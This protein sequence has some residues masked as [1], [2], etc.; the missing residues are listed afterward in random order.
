MVLLLVRQT[1]HSL[2]VPGW[3][4][5]PALLHDPA[6]PEGAVRHLDESGCWFVDW[7]QPAVLP[8][9]QVALA[10]ARLAHRLAERSGRC[11]PENAW[12]AG[13][14]APLGWLA[15][16]AV[17]P[18]GAAAGRADPAHHR[19]PLQVERRHW[20]LDQSAVARRLAR[21]W[22]LPGWLTGVV[23]RLGLPADTARAL[24]SDA[25]LFRV[26][27]LAAALAQRPGQTLHLPVGS[28]VADNA[29]ALGLPADGLEAL[30]Q[31][32]A[33]EA[34]PQPDRWEP[35]AQQ[36]LLRDLL[37]LAAENRRLRGT[38]PLERLENELDELYQA[39]EGQCSG[40]AERLQARK[41]AALAEFA[42]GAGH[43]INNPL[44]VISGQAQYLLKQLQ[45]AERRAQDPE[46]DSAG[47]LPHAAFRDSLRV[48]IE[49][50][51]RIHSI[52][53]DLWRFARPPEPDRQP[54]DLHGLIQE[55]EASLREL[56]A[57]RK[58]RLC[59]E[60]P[61]ANGFGLPPPLTVRADA[62]QLR[63][64]LACLM[65]NAIEAAPEEGWARVRLETP[66]P[67]QVDVLIEDSGTPPAPPQREHLFDPF[68][69][70]RPAG[71]GR[72][73]GLPTAWRLVRA[74][75]GDVRLASSA[76][77]EPTRFIL[78]LPRDAEANGEAP[79][80]A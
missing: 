50:S 58:V 54:I 42:A 4:F 20:G 71:R 69:S 22:G 48:I 52:L 73:L 45:H 55:V 13:L 29:A 14:L 41:L 53:R 10:I 7:S 78:S 38:A 46:A 1:V 8:I 25:D 43:E 19:H 64:A 56:A 15:V 5:Y 3:S 34:P 68:Y 36:P 76:P 30:A 51:Q 62:S 17:D 11:D 12:V 80:S 40:E 66:A 70:G 61:A 44:A 59:C 37:A 2:N 16:A 79:A 60:R 49:Q 63:T 18:A 31:E 27:Q 9:Y 47:R 24:G 21:H 65:R 39:L 77:G 26:V 74:H 75:G 28:P 6:V 67:D 33:E 32:L 35:P 23:G 72:G 57:A